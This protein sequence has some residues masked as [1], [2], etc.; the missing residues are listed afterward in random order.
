FTV[1]DHGGGYAAPAPA[2]A[3][4]LAHR[5]ALAIENARL[6]R[7]AQEVQD[8]LTQQAAALRRSNEELQRFAY[9]AAHDLQAPLRMVTAYVQLL[10]RRF[11]AA[12]DG[13]ARTFIGYA[14]DGA[15]RMKALI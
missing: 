14:V 2:G 15:K 13:D 3:E 4:E 11:E 5:A 8:T 10:A 6:Y 9:L 7:A 12:L 1:P